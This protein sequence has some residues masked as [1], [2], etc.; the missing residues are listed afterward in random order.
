MQQVMQQNCVCIAPLR[1]AEGVQQIT[2]VWRACD[3]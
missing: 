2:E 3:D 1:F